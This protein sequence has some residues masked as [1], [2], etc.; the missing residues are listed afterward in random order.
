M[1]LGLNEEVTPPQICLGNS[2]GFLMK[3]GMKRGKQEYGW[4]IRE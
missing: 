1:E 3:Q 2:H 4:N